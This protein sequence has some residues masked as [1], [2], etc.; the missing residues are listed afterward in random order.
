MRRRRRRRRRWRRK[1]KNRKGIRERN[2]GLGGELK[3]KEKGKRTMEVK[4]LKSTNGRSKKS[5]TKRRNELRMLSPK[6][7]KHRK[8]FRGKMAGVAR[9]GTTVA[10]GEFGLVAERNE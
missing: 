7:V 1:R 3:R 9:R 8:T 6:R 10:F 5:E 4:E 2:G